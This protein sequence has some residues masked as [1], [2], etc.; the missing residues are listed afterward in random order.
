MLDN[1]RAGFVIGLVRSF[2]FLSWQLWRDHP[3][4]NGLELLLQEA[5]WWVPK[6]PHDFPRMSQI[7]E[8]FQSTSSR[9]LCCRSRHTPQIKAPGRFPLHSVVAWRVLERHKAL[10]RVQSLDRIVNRTCWI[11]HLVVYNTCICILRNTT[12]TFFEKSSGAC[13]CAWEGSL[14]LH[15]CQIFLIAS[16]TGS[17][18]STRCSQTLCRRIFIPTVARANH[19]KRLNTCDTLPEYSCYTSLSKPDMLQ[20]WAATKA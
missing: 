13:P 3:A 16:G 2:G 17:S 5:I 18:Q 4:H 8:N 10:N 9:Q 19:P 7:F 15:W 6:C 11:N 20:A 12:W 1:R 14:D